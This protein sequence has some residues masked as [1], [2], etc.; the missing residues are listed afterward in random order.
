MSN[1]LKF[2]AGG[3]VVVDIRM[4]Q[5]QAHEVHLQFAVSDQGIGLSA[6]QTQQM[7]LPFAQADA[8]TTR[9]YGGTGLGLAICKH[10]VE[11]M[12]GRI[13][14]ESQ[15]GQG[16]TFFFTL[17]FGHDADRRQ[18]ETQELAQALQGYAGKS[19]VLVDDNAIARATLENLLAP[20]GLP[21]LS[22][23]DGA[24]VVERMRGPR[25][26]DVL[27]FLVDWFMPEPDG[28]ETIRQLR[29]L[30]AEAEAQSPPMLLVTAHI[31]DDDLQQ[32][33]H[34]IDG[35][36]SKP[37]SARRLGNEIAAALG[38]RSPGQH[39][40]GS[41]K[42]DGLDWSS[43]RRLDILLVED[44]E[45]NREV[46]QEL[47]GSVGLKLRM[48]G[49]GAEALAAIAAQTPDLVLMDCQM[50]VMDGYTATAK[51]RAQPQ[52]ADMPIV[53]LTAG[54][55][56]DDKRR[57]FAAGMNGYVSKPVRLESLYE[58]MMLCLPDR[59]EAVPVL[60][61]QPSGPQAQPPLPAFP[62]IDGALGLAHVGGRAAMYV[63]VLKKFR[64]NQCLHFESQFAAAIQA[65]E[66]GVAARLAHSL[67]GVSRTLGANDLAERAQMLEIA[68]EQRD[69]QEIGVTLE[70]VRKHLRTVTS[71][72][73]G[74]EALISA[75]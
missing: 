4:L 64:D 36:V 8:S 21:V 75:S 62:G 69:A 5:M 67:K 70:A 61:L 3:N 30:Y 63:R 18:S 48:A 22:F 9:R 60:P 54:A 74:L 25:P 17:Q 14:V 51:L 45:V 40:S 26:P 20:L 49:N 32:V 2:S 53:A 52:Y 34:L 11:L 39:K 68:L 27:L 46:M 41:R 43:L 55:M 56:I 6:E 42:S 28:I 38:L 23:A 24:A 66:W 72:L 29:A 33:D 7:F 47:L 19:M 44:V 10:L 13:W 37:I 65:E 16:S 50:P 71:G 58:Q 12:G 73:A 15:P 59:R 35:L 31:Y 1:A 57:C